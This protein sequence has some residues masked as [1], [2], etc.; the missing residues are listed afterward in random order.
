M[1]GDIQ[2]DFEIR[3]PRYTSYPTAPHFG[4]DVG[5]SVFA[6]WLGELDP[7][8]KLSLYFHIPFCRSL[9]HFCGCT[10]KIVGRYDPVARYLDALVREI[11]L[12]AAA[13]PGRFGVSHVHF[14]GGSPT[15]LKPDD[16]RALMGRIED[17]FDL[18]PDAEIAVEMDPRGITESYI[19]A[20][21]NSGVNRVSIGVQDIDPKVQRAI[22]RVQPAQTTERAAGWLIKHGI[23]RFNVDLMYGLPHQT[24]GGF[25]R[26]V[27][28]VAELGPGRVAVFGYAHVPWMRAHQKLIDEALLPDGAGR[29]RA[30]RAISGGL[31]DKGY[32]AIGLDH[33]ALPGDGLARARSEHRLR[34]NFQGYTT[35]AADGLI[36]FGASAIS[37]LPQGLAQNA[38]PIRAYETAIGNRQ[39][40]AARGIGLTPEDRLRGEIIERLMCYLAADVDEVRL[41]HGGGGLEDCFDRLKPLARGGICTIDGGRVAVADEHRHMVRLVA[42]AFDAYLDPVAD[43]TRYSRAV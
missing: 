12:V 15:M 16:W 11:D 8:Q 19:E 30:F 5:P 23:T 17:A 13:L 27:D 36:G 37:S 35:D 26:L 29:L 32:L 31:V 20:L 28:F 7:A 21:A 34:R 38:V 33:F 22:G 39:F 24:L 6:R 25:S 42:A 1:P 10:T 2:N 41:K 4:D 14:G 43:K 40:A 18:L 9:C 3:V